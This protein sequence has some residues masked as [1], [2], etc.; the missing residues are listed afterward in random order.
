MGKPMTKSQLYRELA[1][2]VELPRKTV[3]AF[4]DELTN[5]AM[6]ETRNNGVF[7][8]PGF[9]KLRKVNRK[10]RMGRNP[11]TGEAIKIPAKTVVR[12]RVSKACKEAAVGKK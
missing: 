8:L 11:Q 12:F 6:K 7:T 4:M 10:A 2:N 3:V 5:I 1:E 9:G